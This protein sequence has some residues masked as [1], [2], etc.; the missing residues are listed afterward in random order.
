MPTRGPRFVAIPNIPPVGVPEWQASILSAMKENIEL[1][2]GAR[3]DSSTRAI[4]KGQFT[5]TNPPSQ[6]MTRV[7]AQGTGFVINGATVPS[8]EDYARL[9]NNVQELANDV[10]NLRTTL[11][12][13]INQLK[14]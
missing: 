6:T 4:V 11:N 3:G 13:L 12:T 2:I 8:L 1:L 9:I 14:G 7:T 5:V 10:A